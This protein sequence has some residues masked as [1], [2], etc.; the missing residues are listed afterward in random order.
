MFFNF[1][2]FWTRVDFDSIPHILITFNVYSY[3]IELEN[4]RVLYTFSVY[5]ILMA[6]QLLLNIFLYD[7]FI[8]RKRRHA[9]SAESDVTMQQISARKAVD[10]V[11]AASWAVEPRRRD[12]LA[13]NLLQRWPA[14]RTTAA[15]LFIVIIDFN[16]HILRTHCCLRSCCDSI[17]I[18]G[19]PKKSRYRHLGAILAISG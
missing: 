5:N 16:I 12:G 10:N 11:N 13:P 15:C 7:K 6:I 18:P 8:Q 14:P 3:K 17:T 1:G 9:H 19:L 4:F 2:R